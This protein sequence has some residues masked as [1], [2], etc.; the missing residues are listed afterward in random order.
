MGA[1]QTLYE[2]PD[3]PLSVG[4]APALKEAMSKYIAEYALADIP[5]DTVDLRE[6]YTYVSFT[7]DEEL[8]RVVVEIAPQHLK[9]IEVSPGRRPLSGK[10]TGNAHV[11]NVNVSHTRIE[12]KGADGAEITR[13]GY[14]VVSRVQEYV[15]NT[16]GSV[17]KSAEDSTHNLQEATVAR[18]FR[19]HFFTLGSGLFDG[20]GYFDV[21]RKKM[22]GAYLTRNYRLNPNL[23]VNDRTSIDVV[24]D[25]AATIEVE[26]QGQIIYRKRF[27]PGNYVVQGLSIPQ[28]FD[29][30]VVRKIFLDGTEEEETQSFF[31]SSEVFP[32]GY[33]DFNAYAGVEY[34]TTEYQG[35]AA[36]LQVDGRIPVVESFNIGGFFQSV[37]RKNSVGSGL[38]HTGPYGTA[39]YETTFAQAD[40]RHV[41]LSH[42]L[43]YEK[44]L[45]GV[46]FRAEAERQDNRSFDDEDRAGSMMFRLTVDHTLKNWNLLHSLTREI[47][48]N[49]G[50]AGTT[51]SINAS[52]RVWRNGTLGFNFR[53]DTQSEET[54]AMVRLTWVVD[55]ITGTASYSDEGGNEQ[56]VSGKLGPGRAYVSRRQEQDR[57]SRQMRYNSSTKRGTLEIAAS[58]VT[59]DGSDRQVYS[60]FY[61]GALS[62]LDGDVYWH[63]PTTGSYAVASF[64]ENSKAAAESYDVLVDGSI[65]ERDVTG[66]SVY[67]GPL[68]DFV[69]SKITFIPN[70]SGLF[71]T[72]KPFDTVVDNQRRTG[73]HIPVSVRLPA[74]ISGR[75]VRNDGEP[76]GLFSGTLKTEK[77]KTTTYIFTD[78]RGKF[79]IEQAEL[80][81]FQG[82]LRGKGAP[83]HVAIDL[84][85]VTFP[86]PAKP[87]ADIG[88][89]RCRPVQ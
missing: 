75:V 63:R 61:S 21:Q 62:L 1:F 35:G 28:R 59:G 38:Y 16:R 27:D 68:P 51:Y 78:D 2:H 14:N 46:G 85:G 18:D 83:C 31:R 25:Q 81:A 8:L 49:G 34:D 89:I 5:D 44:Y 65:Y 72:A 15:A 50:G 55:D 20:S 52:R 69:Q 6:K 76:V 24:L 48:E 7:F 12:T 74:N 88:D 30:V 9:E 80:D 42:R 64:D 53:H 45:P 47:E 66:D 19:E 57:I 11:A 29:S 82:V 13:A 41:S 10:A 71:D 17:S 40:N 84:R 4:D 87:L 43:R 67:I 22:L 37:D 79:L 73:V 58:D 60:G 54:A 32:P 26:V 33:Y 56:T 70:A 86:D 23:K 77:G 36:V 39:A 3:T